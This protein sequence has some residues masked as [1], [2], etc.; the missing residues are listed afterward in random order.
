MVSSSSGHYQLGCTSFLITRQSQFTMNGRV[1][2]ERI[3]ILNDSVES[4]KLIWSIPT[5][6]LFVVPDSIFFFFLLLKQ[7]WVHWRH[8]D[9]LYSFLISVEI[10]PHVEAQQDSWYLGPLSPR[11]Q[12]ET[13]PRQ[14]LKISLY[15]GS[16]SWSKHSLLLYTIIIVWPQAGGIQHRLLKSQI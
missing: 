10:W 8:S 14:V 3:W 12:G 13:F 6:G 7:N 1:A 16:C 15:T 4:L 5:S 11:Q 2:R 9:W